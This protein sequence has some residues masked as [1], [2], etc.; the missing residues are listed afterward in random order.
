MTLEIEEQ[1]LDVAK[2]SVLEV[3]GD[4][5]LEQV[6]GPGYPGIVASLLIFPAKKGVVAIL[7]DVTS[8]SP[9]FALRASTL[10][11]TKSVRV[12]LNRA[13]AMQLACALLLAAGVAYAFPDGHDIKETTDAE[14]VIY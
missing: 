7:P 9:T 12:A 2:G 10:D 5:N 6:A 1:Y 11:T 8:V 14:H 4:P 3:I 13:Q